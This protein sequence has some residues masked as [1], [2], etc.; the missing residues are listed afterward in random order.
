M[1]GCAR[2][3]SADARD[4]A[5]RG[6]RAQL[7]A[8]CTGI[9]ERLNCGLGA[10]QLRKALYGDLDAIIIKA[11]EREPA[12]RYKSAAAFA[13]DLTHYLRNEPVVARRIGRLA[14]LTKLVK[15]NRAASA[16]AM[17]L[18]LVLIGGSAGI[19][20]EALRAEREAVHA[21]TERRSAQK[22]PCARRPP[23]ISW[24]AF[25]PQTIRALP[26]KR[27]ADR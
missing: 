18:L 17:S 24:S 26:P 13:D 4:A 16:L 22:K 10:A 11:L 12:R 27:R 15:R 5:R 19:A 1:N 23:R 25:S 21:E 20:R 7:P 9:S 8:W 6:L 14:Q 2:R 3:R